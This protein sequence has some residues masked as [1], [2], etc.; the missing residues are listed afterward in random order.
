MGILKRNL[1]KNE[2]QVVKGKGHKIGILKRNLKQNEVQFVK[3]R[4]IK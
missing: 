4:A 1:K 2:V 3:G